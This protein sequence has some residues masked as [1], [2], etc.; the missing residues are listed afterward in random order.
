MAVPRGPTMTFYPLT[1]ERCNDAALQNEYKTGREIGVIRLGESVLFFRVKLKTYYV[2]YAGITRVFRR[3]QLVPARMC[4]GR[5]N[6]SV[7]NLVICGKDEAEIA[8]IQLPGDRA[9]KALIEE[10]KIRIPD[11]PFICPPKADNKTEG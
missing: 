9:A 3:V 8:Q 1:D 7:E 6:L 11:I 5:G 10:L 2:P 4:C